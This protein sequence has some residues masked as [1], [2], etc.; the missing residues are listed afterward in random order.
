MESFGNESK[1]VFPQRHKSQPRSC[2][3]Q[4]QPRFGKLIAHATHGPAKLATN[5]LLKVDAPKAARPLASSVGPSKAKSK[6]QL[7]SHVFK[8]HRLPPHPRIKNG[9]FRK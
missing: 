1:P 7:V 4:H 6:N 2:S 5:K 3:F 9:A 8:A